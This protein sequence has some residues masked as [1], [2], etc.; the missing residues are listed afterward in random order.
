MPSEEL[1]GTQF[2][3][4]CTQKSKSHENSFTVFQGSKP[5][6][7]DLLPQGLNYTHNF[8]NVW[9]VSI[10]WSSHKAKITTTTKP[11]STMKMEGKFGQLAKSSQFGREMGCPHSD[12]LFSENSGIINV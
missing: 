5:L 3:E 10:F 7:P 8:L 12:T 9:V 2:Y 11:C 1:S 6:L 4:A